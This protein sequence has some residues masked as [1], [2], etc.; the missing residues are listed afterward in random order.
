MV[1]DPRNLGRWSPENT[2][3]SLREGDDGPAYV[4]MNFWGHNK[5]GMMRWATQCIVTAAD[6]GKCF[7]FR[8]VGQRFGGKDR[9]RLRFDIATWEYRFD[10]I[11][12]GTRVTETW[13]DDRSSS[14]FGRSSRMGDR[15]FTGGR[16]FADLHSRNMRVTLERLKTE[17]ETS[18]GV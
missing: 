9:A 7:A 15:L 8:V 18:S 5:R 3:A 4:G 10:E 13:V 2:S 11:E 12:D 14:W 17:M 1:S 6:P 16:S